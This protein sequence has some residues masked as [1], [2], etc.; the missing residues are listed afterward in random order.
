MSNRA[1]ARPV[2]GAGVLIGTL[3]LL[4]TALPGTPAFAV[5]ETV[6]EAGAGAERRDLVAR[7]APWSGRWTAASTR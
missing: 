4:L 1:A 5:P 2:A 3:L 7:E 6:R